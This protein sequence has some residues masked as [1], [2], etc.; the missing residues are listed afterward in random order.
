MCYAHQNALAL[1]YRSWH[2]RELHTFSNTRFFTTHTHSKVNGTRRE[3]PFEL[4]KPQTC[5]LPPKLTLQQTAGHKV[6]IHIIITKHF[7]FKY[8][9]VSECKNQS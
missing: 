4:H 7:L 8:I 5:Q 6:R 9:L 3:S 1:L 2:F